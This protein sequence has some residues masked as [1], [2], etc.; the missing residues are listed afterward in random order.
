MLILASTSESG[1]EVKV[2]VL[3]ENSSSEEFVRLWAECNTA[4]RDSLKWKCTEK[5]HP[6]TNLIFQEKYIWSI[7]QRR[8]TPQ[9]IEFSKKN[10]TSDQLYREEASFNKLNFPRKII[11]LGHLFPTIWETCSEFC[12]FCPKL[13]FLNFKEEIKLLRTLP[14]WPF[15]HHK[16]DF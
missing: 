14:T 4:A 11:H 3:C 5:R 7:I 8:G 6:S 1:G 13:S 12:P 16:L 9:Q 2:K 10:Y 15:L